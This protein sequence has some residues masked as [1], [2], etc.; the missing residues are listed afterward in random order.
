MAAKAAGEMVKAGS[1]TAKV[2]R[3]VRKAEQMAIVEAAKETPGFKKA[4]EIRGRKLAV[5]EQWGLA[6]M[7]PISKILGVQQEYFQ[8]E[9][10]KDFGAVIEDIPEENLQTPKAIIAGPVV[11]GLGYSLDEPEL[12]QLYLELLARASDDRI[13]DSAHPSFV[14]VIRQL[15]SEEARLLPPLLA[16]RAGWMTGMVEFRAEF[17]NMQGHQTLLRHVIDLRDDDGAISLH[18][19]LDT[20][21]DNW[22]R[23]GLVDVSYDRHLSAPDSY[24]WVDDRPEKALAQ[25]AVKSLREGA[26]WS[27][28]AAR[29]ITTVALDVNKGVLGATAFG[30]QFAT[31]VGM[32]SGTP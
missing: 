2:G 19:Q 21:V 23:L 11:E 9:F 32:G 12:K 17:D 8:T 6:I 31:S 26:E 24:A 16:V 10:A 18:A 28:L 13:A 20:F 15:T 7:K 25:S 30:H 14:E 1:E 27:R 5:K 29:G 3:D 4:A 22:S